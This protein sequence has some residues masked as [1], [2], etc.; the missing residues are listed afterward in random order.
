MIA[1]RSMLDGPS[2]TAERL[3]AGTA[4][5]L[6]VALLAGPRVAGGVLAVVAV[7]AAARLVTRRRG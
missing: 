2:R 3:L 6:G 1:R 7:L 5:G 4:F